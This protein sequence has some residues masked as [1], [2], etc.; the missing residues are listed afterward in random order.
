MKGTWGSFTKRSDKFS[1]HSKKVILVAVWGISGRKNERSEASNLP[2][3][4]VPAEVQ[5]LEHPAKPLEI[6]C[7]GV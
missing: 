7:E 4:E 2:N 5:V 6:A 1:L 3:L